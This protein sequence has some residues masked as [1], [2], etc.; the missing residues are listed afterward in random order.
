MNVLVTDRTKSYDNWMVVRSL[1]E[2]VDIV[3]SVDVLVYNASRESSAD[4]IS[5]LNEIYKKKTS[6]KIIYVCSKDKVDN[7]VM[8]LITGGLTGKYI[9][10][11]FFL[12]N[13]RELNT[14]LT[15]LSVIV[16]SAEL[17]SSVVLQDFFNRYMEDNTKPI[18]KGYLSVVKRAAIEMTEAYHAKSL[19]MIKM[20]ES[21]AEI[22]GTSLDLVSQMKETKVKLEND[23]QTLKDKNLEM[24]NFTSR[25]VSG[26]SIVFYPRVSYAKNKKIIKI[27]DIG[28]CPYLFSFSLGF[29]VY[30]DRIKNVRPKL[31]I[32]E[33]NG[34]LYEEMYKDFPWVTHLSKNDMRNYYHSVVF[35]NSPTSLV[36]T[37]LIDDTDYDTIIVL[38]RT[39]NYKEHI[40]NS[41]GMVAYAIASTR[42]IDYFKLPISSCI[43][44]VVTIENSMLSIP[45]LDAYPSRDDQRTNRY[46]KDCASEFELLYNSFS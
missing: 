34:S 8:M 7:A 17:S 18:S 12:E 22:F 5:L 26:S 23:I 16:E 24:G 46:L 25:N 38:D 43:T 44:S 9:S 15:D 36:L 39:T 32:V 4:K 13:A 29:R 40:V 14:L 1:Q 20:S 6:C 10:D 11:E 30:L 41:K 35:T 33:P 19:E 28:N 31:L 37:K 21:A 27:K 42:Y 2:V 45:L 3:G